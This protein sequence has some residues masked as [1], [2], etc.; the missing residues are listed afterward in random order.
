[1]VRAAA[2]AR[3]VPVRLAMAVARVE[4]MSCSKI[5][6]VGERG[7]MQV[8]PQTAHGMGLHPHSCAQWV[9]AGV[10]YLK[11]AISMHGTGCGGATAYNMGIY[12]RHSFCTGYGRTVMALMSHGSRWEARWTP[13]KIVGDSGIGVMGHSRSFD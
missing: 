10:R 6:R 13:R 2:E 9:D 8:R 5:G 12:T 1:M 11:I 4:G 7:P 3:G